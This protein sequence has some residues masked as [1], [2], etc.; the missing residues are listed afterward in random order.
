MAEEGSTQVEVRGLYDKREITALLTATLSGQLL[1]RQLLYA[2]KTLRCHPRQSFPSGWDIYHS[3]THW[4][5]EDTMLHFVKEIII[6][7]VT[8]TRECL[9][10]SQDQ[11]ALAIFDVFAAHKVASLKD[12]LTETNIILVYVPASCTSELQPLEKSLN[13]PYKKELLKQCFIDWYASEVKEKLDKG[14]EVHISLYHKGTACKLDNQN[15]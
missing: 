4:S 3:P 9:G 6:P 14:E 12:L 7:Y 15:T 5:T 13:D 10:L 11:K 8:A 1:S 2:G